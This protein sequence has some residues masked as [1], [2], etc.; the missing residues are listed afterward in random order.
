MV[1]VLLCKIVIFLGQVGSL[2]SSWTPVRTCRAD[3]VPICLMGTYCWPAGFLRP[4]SQRLR[5]LVFGFSL[6]VVP[7]WVLGSEFMVSLADTFYLTFNNDQPTVSPSSLTNV[8]CYL[9]QCKYIFTSSWYRL[10]S[11]LKYHVLGYSKSQVEE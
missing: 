5:H 6:A 7:I 11:N 8:M 9:P 3:L 4:L 1:F 10:S 2:M